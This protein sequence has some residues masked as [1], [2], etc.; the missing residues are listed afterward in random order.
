MD[1][2]CIGKGLRM[3]QVHVLHLDDTIHTFQ[4]SGHSLGEELFATVVDRFRLLEADYFDLE[5]VNDEGL[6]NSE[7]CPIPFLEKSRLFLCSST[8]VTHLNYFSLRSRMYCDRQWCGLN[9]HF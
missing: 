4:I 6:R 5:Y 8:A 3:I 7:N 1:G 9:P 2:Q